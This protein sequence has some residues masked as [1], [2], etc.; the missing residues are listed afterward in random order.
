M[1]NLPTQHIAPAGSLRYVLRFPL[2]HPP[3]LAAVV[4]D[5]AV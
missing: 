2:I 3:L 4:A 1:I 5:V